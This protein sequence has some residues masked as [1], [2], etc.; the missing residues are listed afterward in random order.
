MGTQYDGPQIVG[1][2]LHRRR[3]VL[4]RMT[5]EGERLGKARIVNSPEA[6]REEVGKAGVAPRVVLEATYGW[7][8]AADTLAAA[9]AEVHLAHPLGVKAFTYRRVKNDERDAA[10]L[11]DLL[12]MG[13]LP[14]AWI[15]PREVRELRELTRYRAK[16]VGKWTGCKDMVH[17]VLAKLGIAVVCSD[18]FGPGG[19]DWLDRLVLPQPYRGKVASLRTLI[20]VVSEEITMLDEV[21]ADLLAGHAGYRVIQQLHG[22]GPVLAAVIVAEVGDVTRFTRPEQLCS[23]AGLTPRHRESDLKVARGPITKQG[24]RVLRWAM[25][26]AVQRAR[27]GTKIRAVKD[28]IIARRGPQARNIAKTAAARVLLTLVFYGLRDGQIRCLRAADKPAA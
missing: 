2:D 20:A 25:V 15:A 16:L 19:T 4:V 28:G 24:S 13:R 22:I 7:Y 11:A 26:E 1:M 14:E 17:A 6:L 27:T 8:W 23:W 3:S 12:R 21:I 18:L 9:G 10:D 5:P